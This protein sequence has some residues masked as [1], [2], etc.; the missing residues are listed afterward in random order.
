M[1]NI[2]FF[3]K[4]IADDKIKEYIATN[5][6]YLT[7]KLYNIQVAISSIIVLE[8]LINSLCVVFPVGDKYL[9]EDEDNTKDFAYKFVDEK[10]NEE[11]I[12][13]W[14]NK[15]IYTI[16]DKELVKLK[17]TDYHT[18]ISRNRHIID[19]FKFI[20]E[21]YFEKNFIPVL[22]KKVNINEK[23]IC[24]ECDEEFLCKPSSTK[25]YCS[26]TC[27]I[28]HSNINRIL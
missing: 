23:R 2:D 4:G 19:F 11:I 10:E 1:K 8:N 16:Y 17:N 6:D 24:Q 13:A 5:S 9:D 26:L 28:S 22:D 20:I 25:K 7:K 12:L 18:I 27:S 21:I 14:W 3:L 15:E